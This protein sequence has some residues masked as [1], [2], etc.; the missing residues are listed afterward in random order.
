MKNSFNKKILEK[1]FEWIKYNQ[2]TVIITVVETWGSSPK[3]I[4]SKM[5]V[6][7]NKNFFGSV[8]G[9]CVESFIIQE[10]LNIIKKMNYLRLKNLKFQMKVHGMWVFLVVGK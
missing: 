6:N 4:A 3:P 7:E 10:S 1:A 2:T 9:G 5:I 8:S